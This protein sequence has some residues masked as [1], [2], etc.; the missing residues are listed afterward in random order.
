MSVDRLF[1]SPTPWGH[2]NDALTCPPPPHAHKSS[3]SFAYDNTYL[4]ISSTSDDD[5]GD[6][7]DNS[8]DHTHTN[9]TKDDTPLFFPNSSS[10]LSVLGTNVS[11]TEVK[12]SQA[13]T[14]MTNRPEASFTLKKRKR[15]SP[16]IRL[17][18]VQFPML[19]LYPAKQEVPSAS[20]EQIP[21]SKS[22]PFKTEVRTSLPPNIKQRR[23]TSIARCA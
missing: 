21:R 16:E 10:I 22:E 14:M 3:V 17:P 7:D 13:H 5:D 23:R 2:A 9:D 15:V 4:T 19:P 12:Y 1:T 6:V 8:I 11:S 18:I 20:V